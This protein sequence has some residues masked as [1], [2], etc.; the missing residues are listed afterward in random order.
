MP[1]LSFQKRFTDRVESGDKT[2]SIRTRRKRPEQWH[3]GRKVHL[4][5]AMRT[6]SCR[7]LG[8]GEIIGLHDLTI[9]GDGIYIDGTFM[10]EKAQLHEF[11]VQDGFKDWPDFIAFFSENYSLPFAGSLIIWR[12]IKE[13]PAP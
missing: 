1:S 13:Q 8:T 12:L 6:R 4:F 9:T 2:H 5:T 7:R 11:A 3:V 10:N